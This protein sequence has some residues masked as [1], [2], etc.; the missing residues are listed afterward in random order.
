MARGWTGGAALIALSMAGAA[1]AQ[2]SSNL[3]PAE[4]YGLRLQYREFRPAL[5]GEVQ[6][7]SSDK[8]GTVVDVMD[9]LGIADKRTFDVRGAVQFK[10]GWKLRGS[11][12]PLDYKGDTEVNSS[13]TYGETRYARFDRV[14]TTVKGAYYSAD[15]EWDFLKG[16]RGFLGAVVGA[17][18][19]D[20]D[21][22]LVDVSVNS[23]EL[24]TLTTPIP[25]IGMAT[26]L[27]AGRVSVEGE[28][29]GLSVGSRGSALEAEGSVRVH[30][31]DRLAAMGGYR[32]L[33]LDGKAGRDQV[34]LKLSGWQ[35]GLELSL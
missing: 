14:V 16:P 29:A 34:K 13:F 24:D 32:Y 18:L 23:R 10:K 3:P 31:S 6:K 12:T 5:T 1:S 21:A 7:G 17:K 27:Y 20:V 28:L 25:V 4:K 30:V 33:S 19:F 26:R 8:D 35:F 2:D 22:A 15:L 11:Y 9:D